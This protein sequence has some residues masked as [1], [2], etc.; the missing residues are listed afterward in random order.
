MNVDAS[1]NKPAHAL[2]GLQSA[3]EASL[4]FEVASPGFNIVHDM[5]ITAG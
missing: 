2:R 5:D 1:E 3:L 4:G